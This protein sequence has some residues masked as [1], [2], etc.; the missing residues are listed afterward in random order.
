[1]VN[2]SQEQF[3]F[4]PGRSTTE[5]IFALRQ[6]VEKYREGQ[7][8][9]H[10]VFIDMEKAYDRVSRAE[11]WNCLR[12]KGVPEGCVRLIQDMYQGAQRKFDAS[13]GHTGLQGQRGSTPGLSAEPTT[14]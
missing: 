2:I 3:G 12:L 11:V 5:A 7:Q 8:N 10:C 13:W 6:V 9:V 4:M 14:V 1:M